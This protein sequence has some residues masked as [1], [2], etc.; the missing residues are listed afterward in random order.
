VTEQDGTQPSTTQRRSRKTNTANQQTDKPTPALPRPANDDPEAWKAYWKERGQ[1]WRTEPEIDAVRQALLT[2]RRSIPP[3]I[4]QG[5]YPWKDLKLSRADVEWL[6]ATHEHGRGPVLW[7]EEQDKAAYERRIGLDLRGA[8]VEEAT[9]LTGLPLARVRGGLEPG[10]WEPLTAEQR[11]PASLCLKGAL[12]SWAHLEGAILEDAHLERAH[13]M[14]AHLE[15]ADLGD[16]HLEGADLLWAHLEGAD[17]E[18]AYLAGARLRGAVLTSVDLTRA[19]LA[20]ATGVGPSLVDIVWGDNNLAVV[21]WGQVKRLGDEDVATHTRYLQ[22]DS[23][24]EWDER[25]GWPIPHQVGDLK[26]QETQL[27]HYKAAVRANRQLAVVLRDQGLNEE[28]DHFAYRAQV[29]QRVVWRRQRRWVQYAFSWLLAG[30]AGYGYKPSRCFVL[31]VLALSGFTL[32]HY[33]VGAVDGHSLTVLNA[34]AVSVQSLHGRLFSFQSSDPQTLLNTIE[35][36]VVIYQDKNTVSQK[37]CH[38]AKCFQGM[39]FLS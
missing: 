26:D 8:V 11:A 37:T 23:Y 28:A 15:G 36:F 38:T 30:V 18:G 21:E 22:D 5:I 33:L 10:E 34:L 19:T 13:L 17:L 25:T 6:L 24:P 12:L 29:L 31:Y 16:A 27:V 14:D 7:E 9:D 4:K 35:A 3:D 2:E 32:A 1:P 20:N 39:G